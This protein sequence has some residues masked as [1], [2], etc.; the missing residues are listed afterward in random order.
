MTR[1][2]DR[3]IDERGPGKAEGGAVRGKTDEGEPVGRVDSGA[4]EERMGMRISMMKRVRIGDW[5]SPQA[6]M[7]TSILMKYPEHF[8]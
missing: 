4:R 3:S 1:V 2:I 7:P 8:D 6:P 5:R